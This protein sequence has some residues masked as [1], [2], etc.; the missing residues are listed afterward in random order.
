MR[1]ILVLGWAAAF[2]VVRGAAAQP[3]AGERVWREPI[4]YA[5]AAEVARHLREIVPGARISADEAT[6]TLIIVGPEE[7][8]LRIVEMIRR[9]PDPPSDPDARIHVVP[10]RDADASEVAQ[11]LEAVVRGAS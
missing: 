6:N 7:T 1:A 3:A 8:Y 9:A 11:A 10:L 2:F 5:S 4:H